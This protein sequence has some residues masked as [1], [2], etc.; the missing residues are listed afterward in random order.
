LS[1][2]FLPTSKEVFLAKYERKGKSPGTWN[3]GIMA[4]E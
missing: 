2:V 3:D 4:K 1:P